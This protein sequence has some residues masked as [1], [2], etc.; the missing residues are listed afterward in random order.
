MVRAV[1]EIEQE[2]RELDAADQERILHTL[3]EELAGPPDVEVE[4]A[5][6]EE[7]QRR[8][9]E[10]DAGLVTPVAAEEVFARARAKLR[11]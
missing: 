8:S 10:L 7:A 5:W 11:R 6:L 2:I 1:A 4:R 9:A 3:L